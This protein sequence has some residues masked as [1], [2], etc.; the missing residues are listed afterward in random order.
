[1]NEYVVVPLQDPEPPLPIT[2]VT[3]PQVAFSTSPTYRSEYEVVRLDD[4]R[5]F[6]TVPMEFG[7]QHTLP[8]LGF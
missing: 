7:D 8:K 2:Q 6:Q 5:S 4:S 3:V 1:M